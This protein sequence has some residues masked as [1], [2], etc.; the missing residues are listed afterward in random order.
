MTVLEEIVAGVREDVAR[1]MDETPLEQLKERAGSVPPARN[2]RCM[3]AADQIC[4]IAEVKRQSPS[5][6]PL[7]AI[8]DPAQL[9]MEY[10]AGGAH[11]ISVSDR[12]AALRWQSRGLGAGARRGGY[13][14]SAQRLHRGQLPTV[15]SQGV[16]R[17]SGS[18]DRRGLG[19]RRACV[20]RG[21]HPQSG[22]DPACGSP[23]RSRRSLERWMLVRM[24]S[25]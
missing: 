5:R 13:P 1:R 7:A 21:A 11:C 25:V 16:R 24:S 2:A 17:G 4:V 14:D 6:G 18:V 19:A 3:L 12:G 22:D 15:G 9:A 10:E 23:R 8:D 20:A